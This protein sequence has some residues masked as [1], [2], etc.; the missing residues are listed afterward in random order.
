[1]KK[2]KNDAKRQWRTS[3]ARVK[4]GEYLSIG[5][6][7]PD[8][9]GFVYRLGYGYL[10]ELKQ[11][12]DDPLTIIKAIIANFP[13][14]WTKEQARTKL[15]EILKD[16]KETK[17]EV[18]ERFK[19]YEVV[20]KLFDYF[21]I[22]NDCSPTKSTTLKDVV[23]QLIYQ[24]IKNPISVFNTY[25][26]AKKEKI[27]TYSK[28]SFYRSLDYIAKNKDE[29]LRNLNAKICANTNRKIDV[30]WF[31]ATTTYFETFSREGYKKPGYSKDGKF[32]EDQIVIGMAT[33]KNEIPLHYKIFPGNVTDSNTFIPF[34]L[35]IADI[36]EVNSVTII[37]DKGMSVNRNIRF[38]ESKNWKY[39]ISYRMKAGSK[40]FKE[41]VLDE[42]DY[43]ND[44]GLI[45]KTRDIASS[46][47]K[48]RINGHFRRQIISFSQKRATKDK[49]DRDILIQNFTKK[50]NKDNL[51]SCDDL[52]GSK[53][54][55]FFKPI[56]KGAFYELD[57]EK[58]QEDQKYDGYY[59]YET[60]RTDLSVKEV[61]NLY[62]KQWQIESNFKTLK[63]KL[64]LRPMYLSTW[65]HIVGY[66][67]LCFISLVFLNYII[68]IL[69]SKL[70]LTGKSKITEHKVINVIKEVKE[71]EVFVNK[72]KIETIQVYNDELQESWQTYQILLELLT[73]EKV[74]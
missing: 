47:N 17:K 26:T 4:K 21:N 2:S 28:N 45:Y 6:P 19:G 31:D 44:G 20:E 3:I 51:V 36:Y 63:G 43:V 57:I 62:S 14:S 72:Q 39:I 74:T 60:N 12:H 50:M 64:S 11:Y 29:I 52:A 58:I 55:R 10:H 16:K 66:I 22:F 13:L 25:M 54:Y 33:D 38:L 48:K 68:Y 24:R 46:Y 42:K 59:V 27:D 35:E 23:L 71:I 5:V 9:K 49:N 8:N 67:C 40:Q 32:K 15:D 18:L 37:A 30:L 53:K 70:G 41:Y 61:I 34:M 73:K 56:N 7:R 65:N 69:N 1:M